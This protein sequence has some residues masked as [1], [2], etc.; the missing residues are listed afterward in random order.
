MPT[1]CSRNPASL[2][3]CLSFVIAALASVPTHAAITF[4]ASVDVNASASNLSRP[5]SSS[6]AFDG[7]FNSTSPLSFSVGTA[8][9]VGSNFVTQ[10]FD[11]RCVVILTG[12]ACSGL[13][14]PLT[15]QTILDG[16]KP[17]I[18]IIG[19]TA[20]ANASARARA[21]GVGVRVSAANDVGPGNAMIDPMNP[22]QTVIGKPRVLS[23]SHA[24]AS[25]SQQI[26]S[27]L[28]GPVGTSTTITLRGSL[29]AS[30]FLHRTFGSVAFGL[31]EV[32]GRADSPGQRC[33]LTA[34][35]CFGGFSL[36][37]MA[38]PNSL[39][40]LQTG[41][42]SQNFEFS[43]QGKVGDLITLRSFASASADGSAEVDSFNTL[44]LS[45]I[46][47]GDGFSFADEEGLVRIGNRYGFAAAVPEPSSWA[48]WAVGL[49]AAGAAARRRGG[50]RG[51]PGSAA[52]SGK[53]R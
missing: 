34:A 4:G 41:S 29:T 18:A 20:S 24:Q 2:L 32:T 15:T 35:G 37:R 48:M 17:V 14:A 42:V 31:F 53:T 44:T 8:S 49:V 33:T 39:T 28:A 1:P 36:T 10:G 13:E 40:P 51:A 52:E 45:E 46:A 27:A 12:N 21:G 25:A 38:D 16:N 50:R 9:V 6:M 23:F 11:G 3:Q 22:A 7:K 26:V 43:F 47:L 5:P 19:T 30:V